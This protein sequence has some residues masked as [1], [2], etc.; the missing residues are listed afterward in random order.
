MK[1][2]R[3]TFVALV[4]LSLFRVRFARPDLPRPANVSLAAAAVY[5]AFAAWTLYFGFRRATH[6]VVWLAVIAAAA[7]AFYV[8]TVNRSPRATRPAPP[9]P[10]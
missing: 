2:W 7:L 8:F 3:W 9:P 10:R 6:L 5:V 4:A 1:C